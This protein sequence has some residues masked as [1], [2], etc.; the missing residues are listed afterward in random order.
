MTIISAKICFTYITL[1]ILILI[2]MAQHRYHSSNTAGLSAT[3]STIC[4][5]IIFT[6]NGTR[7]INIIFNNRRTVCMALCRNFFL[8]NN[9]STANRTV[10]A[11]GKT[12]C[13]TCRSYCSINY[14]LVTKCCYSFLRNK[15]LITYRTVLTFSKT[16]FCTCCRY[17]SI[18]YFLVTKCCY[19]FL[20]NKN[21]ITYRTVL[22]FSKTG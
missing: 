10:L 2:L 3:N 22:T 1:I 13:C 5:S 21:L 4:N 19:S 18:N 8:R 7:R 16:G 9:Y 20:R 14:F 15:D 6:V 17:C 12:G 11:F